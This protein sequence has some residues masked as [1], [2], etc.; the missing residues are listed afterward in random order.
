MVADIS[1]TNLECK[2][3]SRRDC[4][5][6]T[7]VEKLEDINNDLKESNQEDLKYIK[8]KLSDD[9][10]IKENTN[11]ISNDTKEE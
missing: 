10:K 6:E 1:D 4:S 5:I 3:D 11:T 9:L 8:Q 7:I 2:K